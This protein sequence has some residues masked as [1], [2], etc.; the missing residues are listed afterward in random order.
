MVTLAMVVPLVFCV[1]FD[2]RLLAIQGDKP[3]SV[4]VPVLKGH[5]ASHLRMAEVMLIASAHDVPCATQKYGQVC[6]KQFTPVPCEIMT[7]ESEETL[8]R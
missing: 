6:K 4:D 2:K 7:A 8:E 5:H 3:N 1:L